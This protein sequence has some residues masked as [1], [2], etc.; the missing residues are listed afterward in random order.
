MN[1]YVASSWR[2]DLQP[3]VVKFLRDEGHDVYDF[4]NPDRGPLG[5][6]FS[7]REIDAGW[8]RWTAKQQIEAYEHD[9]ARAGLA[10]DF[11]AMRWADALV[12]VQPSGRSAALELGWAIGAG[13]LTAV[14]MSEG[15]EPELMLRLAD[16]LTVNIFE[17]TAWLTTLHIT[18]DR[19]ER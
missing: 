16:L 5:R 13:K 1:I 3:S 4:K 8:E 11:D 10:A 15:Q 2:N 19:S 12:M 18:K 7:W 17:I 9:L 6:G 14:L